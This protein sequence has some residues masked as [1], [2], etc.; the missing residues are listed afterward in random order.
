MSKL[1]KKGS[2]QG[3]M[4]PVVDSTQPKSSAY[5]MKDSNKT[6]EYVSRRDSIEAKQASG[7][8]KQ[9]YKGRY[10]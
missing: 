7:V 9:E 2:N 6:T 1:A 8:K 3:D 10:D 4:S 5:F